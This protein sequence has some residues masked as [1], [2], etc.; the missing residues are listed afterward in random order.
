MI[1]LSLCASLASAGECVTNAFLE[2]CCRAIDAA[3]ASGSWRWSYGGALEKGD[4][5]FQ[6][7][8]RQALAVNFPNE[9]GEAMSCAGN[10]HN[11]K[12]RGLNSVL[13]KAIMQTQTWRRIADYSDQNGYG[14]C[15]FSEGLEKLMLLKNPDGTRAFWSFVWARGRKAD[16]TLALRGALKKFRARSRPENWS[17]S[18]MSDY[19]YHDRFSGGMPTFHMTGYNE[20]GNGPFCFECSYGTAIEPECAWQKKTRELGRARPFAEFDCEPSW[21]L[22][23]R[24]PGTYT[25]ES[26]LKALGKPTRSARLRCK[27]CSGT[28]TL[29]EY[30]IGDTDDAGRAIRHTLV[31]SLADDGCCRQWKWIAE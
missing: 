3:A 1:S 7:E 29:W 26:I 18:E 6:D 13:P 22:L 14:C 21:R 5:V 12:M 11:P 15:Y 9:Y 30:E 20:N 17:M 31:F 4:A 23:A 24:R 19:F 28:D 10:T 16:V 25:S 27:N 8:I 2:G